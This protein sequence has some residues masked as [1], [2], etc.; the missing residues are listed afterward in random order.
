MS[1]ILKLLQDDAE[2]KVTV[3]EN[4]PGAPIVLAAGV[5]P[6]AV[7]ISGGALAGSSASTI[8]VTPTAT[9]ANATIQ[10]RFVS[11]RE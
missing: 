11:V 1:S 6:I 5:N 7:G 2:A 10:V 3:N 4:E 8:A 9:Q